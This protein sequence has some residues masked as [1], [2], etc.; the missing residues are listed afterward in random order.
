M[1]KAVFLALFA[2]LFL[3]MGYGQNAKLEVFELGALADVILTGKIKMLDG[4]AFT[5]EI[6]QVVAG[7]YTDPTIVVQRFH[8]TKTAKRWGKY[9]LGDAM[10]LWLKRE[11]D[12][13]VIVGENGEG[14][15]M[16]FGS[17]IYLD[18][19]GGALKNTFGNHAPYPA[20]NVYAE[21]V[22][23]PD[24]IAAVQDTKGCFKLEMEEKKS[25]EGT[26]V[27]KRFAVK[28]MEGTELDRIRSK[29]WMQDLIIANGEKHIR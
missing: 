5:F 21:K 7:D 8:N 24:F 18:S 26:V 16:W 19:R 27:V 13:Y 14:E 4:K 28:Q 11:N 20:V 10:I 17:D 3:Q 1:K 6:N 25:P 9:Q 2:F 12:T 29:G 15:K 22:S 23:A